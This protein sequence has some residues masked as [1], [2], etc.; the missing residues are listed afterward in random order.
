M[1]EHDGVVR[2]GGFVAVDRVAAVSARAASERGTERSWRQQTSR[3]IRASWILV[4]ACL[5]NLTSP[6][7]QPVHASQASPTQTSQPKPRPQQEQPAQ[8]PRLTQPTQTHKHS[9]KPVPV[10]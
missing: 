6:S 7:N 1:E 4:Q 2:D 5:P 8:P 9:L 10:P 3:Y